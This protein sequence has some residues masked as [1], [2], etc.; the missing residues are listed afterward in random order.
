MANILLVDPGYGKD[1][2]G[3][4]GK[5]HWSS[6]I[7]HGLCSLSGYLKSHGHTVSLL[8]IRM[9]R[10]YAN[11]EEEYRKIKPEVVGI[12]FRSA[13]Y[14]TVEHIIE[15]IRA[16]DHKVKI[17]LGGAH[18]TAAP[19]DAASMAGVDYVVVGEGEISF[20]DLVERPETGTT[21]IICGQHPDL[22]S[23]P[24]ED[25]DLY[26]MRTS[27]N[28]PNYPGL[29]KPPLITMIT[30]RGCAFTCKFC[31]PHA[32]STFGKKVRY[33][34]VN[35]VIEEIES[36]DRKFGTIETIKFYN[37]DFPAN[38][39]WVY[40]F[41]SAY[42]KAGFKKRLMIQSRAASIAR[43]PDLLPR[44][45][46]IGLKL[47]LFG[48]ESGSQ[49]ILDSLSK[50][51][52]V[53][54]NIK[55]GEICKKHGV[56]FGGSWMFGIPGETG[57]DLK[58][59]IQ[60]A[61]IINANYNSVSYFT[62][63][64]GTYL[65]AMVKNQHLSLLKDWDELYSFSPDK[66]KIKGIDY[67]LAQDAAGEILGLRFG[68]GF[69]GRIARFIYAKSKPYITLRSVLIYVYSKYTTNPLVRWIRGN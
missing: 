65:G 2:F 61:K 33:Q 43:D 25:R 30:C 10:S 18:P 4:W 16:V 68:G 69:L 5:S 17:V 47:V 3:T 35:R 44:L 29:L 36:I 37:S 21:K 42:E 13:D 54:D 55:A 67:R 40:D 63:L 49:R 1:G 41:C 26:D 24:F 32:E 22:D 14:H 56:V 45:K 31:A 6:V 39:K 64:P 60:V 62:P 28:L 66:P 12:T 58:E 53:E 46:S 59:S 50:G 15:H 11:F 9:L 57:S 23:L 48:F 7:H 20:A 27:M 38:R 8:D 34:D 19:E 51:C 52:S